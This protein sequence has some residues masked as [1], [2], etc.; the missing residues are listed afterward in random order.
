M[1]GEGHVLEDLEDLVN[2]GITREERLAGAHLSKDASNRPHVNTR[3]VLTS[4]QQNL[5]RAIPQSDNL[6]RVCAQGDAERAGKTEISQLEVSLAVDEE[7]LGLEI[8]VQNAVAMAVAH[9]VAQLVHELLDDGLAEAHG[10]EVR[11]AALGQGLAAAAV[12]D[13]QRLHVL[14]QIAVEELEDEVQL[15]A[16]GVDDVEELDD[17]GVTHLL[18]EADLADGGG[19]DA[20]VFGFEADLL[21]GDDAAAI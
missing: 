20:F 2:L 19:R 10:L 15:V 16:V 18:E 7:V 21:Q 9:A 3:R 14:L 6:V 4:T 13:G 12:G 11:A 8:A 5:W 1:I 17:V